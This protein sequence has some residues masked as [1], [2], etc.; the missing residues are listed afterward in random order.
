MIDLPLLNPAL[1]FLFQPCSPI[2]CSPC[3]TIASQSITS[4]CPVRTV[5]TDLS[6]AMSSNFFTLF[7]ILVVLLPGYQSI[8]P[9]LVWYT[10]SPVAKTPLSTSCR[11]IYPG[12]CP[13]M[14][15][16][17][18]IRSPRSNLCPSSKDSTFLQALWNNPGPSSLQV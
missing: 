11:A 14:C 3:A 7:R 9:W 1:I 4:L 15:R 13:V 5:F 8:S 18:N 6:L 10:V 2:Y 17:L 16:T 12:E